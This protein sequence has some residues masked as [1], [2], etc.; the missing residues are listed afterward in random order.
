VLAVTGKPRSPYSN[1]IYLDFAWTPS[2]PESGGIEYSLLEYDDREDSLG[3]PLA[4]T[5]ESRARATIMTDRGPNM[6]YYRVLA[7]DDSG[8]I[9]SSEV[10]TV[11]I[12]QPELSQPPAFFDLAGHWARDQVES[13][14]EKGAI[15]GYPDGSFRPDA[16]I[17]RA[18]FLKILI[19]GAKLDVA[20]G[21]PKGPVA[22]FSGHWARSYLET[23]LALD[24]FRLED[25]P[26]GF[27]PDRP[28]TREE[29]GR[30]VGR[31]L[32]SSQSRVAPA[33]PDWISTR[34]AWRPYLQ[35]AVERG[36]L[37]G[38]PDGTFQGRRSATRAEAA[39]IVLRTLAA[40]GR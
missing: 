20:S 19:A 2:R 12:D 33:F 13:L 29:I 26:G 11:N 39:V 40:L 30:I 35:I 32:G 34:P 15:G 3:T 9:V 1:A 7:R 27:D 25:Y 31:L 8:L 14:V 10:L 28:A 6:R 38:Y 36:I 37:Q 22:A 17:T 16:S 21:L 4:L 18:E 24:L 23:A 5:T